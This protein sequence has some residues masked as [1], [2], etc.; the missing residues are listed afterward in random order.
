MYLFELGFLPFIDTY[1]V[2]RLLDHMVALFSVFFSEISILFPIVA[3]PSYIPT[4]SVG[5]V[6]FC[7]HPLQHLLFVDSL[8]VAI[9][10][11]VSD[12]KL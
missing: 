4:N 5:G 6:S 8:M 1:P 9:L 3:A 11:H 10:T 12:T 7:P 2:L